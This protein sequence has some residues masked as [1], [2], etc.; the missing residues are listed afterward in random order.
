MALLIGLYDFGEILH[1]LQ[2]EFALR[3]F[4]LRTSTNERKEEN[5]D[6]ESDSGEDTNSDPPILRYEVE[7]HTFPTILPHI[8][9]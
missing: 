3:R 8:R 2:A 7:I 6:D 5:N 1:V 9:C 4:T